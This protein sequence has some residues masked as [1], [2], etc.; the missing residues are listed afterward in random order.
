M[1]WGKGLT[2]AM[3]AFMLFITTMV[4]TMMS[5]GVELESA[6]YYKKDLAYNAEMEAIGR[7]NAMENRIEIRMEAENVLAIVP[8][9]QFITDVTLFFRR[10]ND[11][12]ADFEIHVGDKRLEKIPNAKMKPGIY[13]IEMRYFAKGKACL[14]KER[15]YL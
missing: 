6:E 15:I 3:I 9:D 2:I 8:A 13:T 11:E 14:Q 5:K 4:V 1:N 7:V 12:T 10:P